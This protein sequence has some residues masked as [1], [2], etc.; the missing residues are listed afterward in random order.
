MEDKYVVALGAAM[1]KLAK[2]VYSCNA[3]SKTVET[4][5]YI[6][7][8][9]YLRE[10]YIGINLPYNT[11]QRELTCGGL[12]TSTESVTIS[13]VTET[14]KE[15]WL[16]AAIK[17]IEFCRSYDKWDRSLSYEGYDYE[18]ECEYIDSDADG[19]LKRAHSIK[20]Y[21]GEELHISKE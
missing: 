13:P 10:G 3:E 1:N 4:K 12:G 8:L 19:R 15:I 21:T 6:G 20:L 11:T 7:E 5:S 14:E 9:D 2:I 17:H 16:A 18:R